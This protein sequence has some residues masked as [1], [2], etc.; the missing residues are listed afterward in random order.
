VS[1]YFEPEFVE[2]K[3]TGFGVPLSHWFAKGGALRAELDNRLRAS[4]AKIYRYFRPETIHYMIDAH[5]ADNYGSAQALW[6]LLFLEN[7]LHLVHD[8]NSSDQLVAVPA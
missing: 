7:W 4:D 6:Q 1:K 2:R 3:K 5:R 8:A